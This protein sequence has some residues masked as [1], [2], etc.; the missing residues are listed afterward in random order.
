MLRRAMEVLAGV[1]ADVVVVA[2]E[3]ITGIDPDHVIPDRIRGKGPLGGLQAA[4][5]RAAD[6]GMDGVFL[7]A[8]DL[9][10][11][12]HRVVVALT[13][14]AAPAAAPRRG[15]DGIEP[16]CAIYAVDLLGEVD[17][18]I[19]GEDLS[20]HALFDE[21][22]GRTVELDGEAFLNV[23]TPADRDRAEAALSMRD[24]S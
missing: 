2:N 1:T 8:C 18:R 7:L 12:D 24:T 22:G 23:N 10:L 20:L 6:D 19:E 15:E 17:R 4:L 9:P 5:H 21:V 16:L 14:A 3:P 11:V 13:D